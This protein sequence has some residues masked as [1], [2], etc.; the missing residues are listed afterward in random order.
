MSVMFWGGGFSYY[1]LDQ[2]TSV[3]PNID[4][5]VYLKV[6]DDEVC[7]SDNIYLISVLLISLIFEMTTTNFF[8]EEEYVTGL[9]NPPTF[10]YISIL[11]QN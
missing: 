9:M 8:G 5:P 10:Y 7:F 1:E 3:T 6:L 4:Q 11:L 2:F